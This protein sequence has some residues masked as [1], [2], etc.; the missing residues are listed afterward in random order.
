MTRGHAV[1]LIAAVALLALAALL[2]VDRL[3]VRTDMSF[4]LP[5]TEDSQSA[6]L[7][8]RLRDGAASSV[9]M[10]GLSGGS[11]EAL[12]AASTSV[13]ASLRASGLFTT[14]E[15]GAFGTLSP[16][17]LGSLWSRRYI[18]SPPLPADAFSPEQLRADLTASLTR[19]AGAEGWAVRDLFPADPTGRL[20]TL[21]GA[22]QGSGGPQRHGGLWMSADG[23]RALL[24]ARSVASGL[25]LAG[26]AR[27]A[28]AVDAA[29][30]PLRASGLTATASGPG[31][32]AAA[33]STRMRG[34]V[35]LISTVASV[36]V[37]GLLLWVF[38]SLPVLILLGLPIA[39]AII[40]GAAVVQAVF[41]S[42]HAVAL[43]F[44]TTLIG[45]AI[46][47]PVHLLTHRHR[48]ET[49]QTTMRRLRGPLALSTLTTLAGFVV[50]SQASFPGLA[51]LGLFAAVGIIV[52]ALT[53]TFVLPA[54]LPPALVPRPA[55]AHPRFL[56]TLHTARWGLAAGILAVTVGAL[57]MGGPRWETNLAAL[58]GLPQQDRDR[59]AALRH[60]LGV[61]DARL[62]LVVQA[63]SPEAV[64]R[65]QE[66][67]RPA[68]DALI[69]KGALRG[70]EMAADL[71][72]S[73]ATQTARQ[74]ALPDAATLAA[75][76][77]E[78]TATMPLTADA[79]APFMA[80]V[81]SQKAATP[82]T[83]DTLDGP[84][85]MRVDALLKPERGGWTGLV[86]PAGVTDAEALRSIAVN[87]G[88]SVAFLDLKTEADGLAGRYLSE[89][90]DWLGW[91]CLAAVLVVSLGLRHPVRIIGT[92]WPAFA[93]VVAT[94]AILVLAGVG[95]T[96][97]HVLAMVLVAGL[98]IDYAVFFGGYSAST[99]QSGTSLRAVVLCSAT[100]VAVFATLAMSAVPVLQA[101]GLTVALGAALS[102][103]LT[104]AFA[105]PAD[106]AQKG[107]SNS[108]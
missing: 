90:L 36:L 69:A 24:V 105:R 95:L 84:L 96:L 97:F 89:A 65:Q 46:D 12:R 27:V 42:V 88:P 94:S 108:V 39:A 72:P 55:A 10:I 35:T 45:V 93:A 6:L 106:I 25:D 99:R 37:A 8:D 28:D 102:L 50:L 77:A 40:A 52:A 98:G 87:A 74:A 76:L 13:A 83:P 9:V 15:N 33:T 71:L 14:V 18:L 101:I 32:I 43:S 3:H 4:F 11:A 91:G 86:L 81:A 56:A 80:A 26:Q 68:L 67:L 47:Y 73:V 61:A 63:D 20:L 92:L 17:R 60:D 104:I 19:L 7:V 34:D 107:A 38:R 64:L 79:L 58:S 66:A 2:L 48:T 51:Q 59:D 21:L 23:Q 29:L 100:T 31:L 75:R 41:G 16:E 85:S 49:A 57:A 1:R 53:T 82:L 70:A 5:G 62:L 44:G 54:L 78:A 22:M 30:T 103:V